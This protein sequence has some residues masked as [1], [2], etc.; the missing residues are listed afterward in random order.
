MGV[1]PKVPGDNQVLGSFW[2]VRMH[3]VLPGASDDPPAAPVTLTSPDF[4]RVE[5][6]PA[7]PST[8][9]QRVPHSQGPK[10]GLIRDN[11]IWTF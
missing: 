2:P 11:E 6:T 3:P 1:K 4:E 5:L 10:R 9:Y 7:P 8:P